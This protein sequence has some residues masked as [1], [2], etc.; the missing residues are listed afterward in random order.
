MPLSDELAAAV[1]TLGR[2]AECVDAV[3]DMSTENRFS[4]ALQA[5]QRLAEERSIPIAVVGGL[6]AIHFGYPAATQDID[7]AVG[8]DSLQSLIEA[9][10]R[11]GLKVVWES[12]LGW[13]TLAH[14]D[15]EINVVPEGGQARDTAPTSIPGPRQMGVSAGLDYATIESWVELKISSGRRKDHAHVVEVL[16]LAQPDTVEHIRSHLH[17]V[18]KQYEQTFLELVGEAEEERRQEQGRR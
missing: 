8:R 9:A 16:K 11:Y 18:H 10:P 3:L 2:G 7:I 13:H 5:L 14:G 6:G 4:R 15:V 12:E 1:T 17:G